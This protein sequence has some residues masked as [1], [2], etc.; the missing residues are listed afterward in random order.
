MD[1][2]RTAIPTKE[3]PGAAG[4]VIIPNPLPVLLLIEKPARSIET[5]LA[6]ITRQ[7]PGAVRLLAS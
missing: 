2:F 5:K 7:L 3:S 1:P 6:A 4:A